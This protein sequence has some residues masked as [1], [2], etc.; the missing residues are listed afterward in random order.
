MLPFQ[1]VAK[2]ELVETVLH[3]A[4]FKQG[5]ALKKQSGSKRERVSGITKLTDATEA[6]TFLWSRGRVCYVLY[7]IE[8]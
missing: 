1:T 6:G 2:S 3:F 5:L 4:Q 7:G 8:H